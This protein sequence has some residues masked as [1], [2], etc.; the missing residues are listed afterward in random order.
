VDGLCSGIQ[1][2]NAASGASITR[3]GEAPDCASLPI[4]IL[5][6]YSEL[7]RDGSIRA[8]WLSRTYGV[9]VVES[10]TA[11]WSSIVESPTFGGRARS[12]ATFLAAP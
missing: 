4:Q 3:L 9:S 5:A 12:R 10:Q 8:T 1:L 6:P 2:A 7:A 11:K